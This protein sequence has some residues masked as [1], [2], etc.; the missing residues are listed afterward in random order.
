[1]NDRPCVACNKSSRMCD[2]S[3]TERN[4][5]KAKRERVIETARALFV[6]WMANSYAKNPSDYHCVTKM[7]LIEAEQFEA[8]AEEYRN[9]PPTAKEPSR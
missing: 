1:M 8:A 3:V 9:Q 5:A 7:L 4:A 2:C 6:Q